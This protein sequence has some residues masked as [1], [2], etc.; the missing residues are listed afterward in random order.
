MAG[1]NL[2]H[3]ILG[4]TQVYAGLSDSVT[5]KANIAKSECRNS[6]LRCIILCQSNIDATESHMDMFRAMKREAEFDLEA[7]DEEIQWVK[8]V[9]DI[10]GR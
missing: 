9:M 4:Q 3:Q 2:H 6:I 8:E 1:C 7:A 5:Q 10:G